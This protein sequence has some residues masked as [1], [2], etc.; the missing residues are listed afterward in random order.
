MGRRTSL[1]A[2][3]AVWVVLC[4]AA[5]IV[6]AQV[7][8]ATVA[9]TVRDAQD[10]AVPGATVTL[11]SDTRGTTLGDAVTNETGDF[12]FPNVLADTYTVRV[13]LQGFKTVTRSDIDVSPGDRVALPPL[14]LEIGGL[15]ETVEVTAEVPLIQAESGERSFA[16]ER[17]SVE[18]LP[19]L[20]RNFASFA[21]LTP[22]VTGDL[23]GMG[24]QSGQEAS[25][26]GGGGQNNVMMDGV[27]AMDTGNNGQMLQMNVES[28][29]QVKVLT[30]GYQAEYG[31]S[32]GLQITAV[33]KSGSNQFR[34]SL[35]DIERNSDWN[36]NTWQRIHNGD[37][38]E[39]ERERDWG[40]T[41]GGPVGRP[42]G[43]NKL[44][45]FYA[46]EYRPRSSAGSINRFRVPTVLEKQGDFSRSV[47]QNGNP[48]NLI[49]DVTTGLPC[50]PGDT[51]GCFQA[52]GVLGRIPQ[53]RLYQTGLNVLDMWGVE[54]NAEGLEF[55]FE[56]P[57]PLVEDLIQ[58]PA[59]RLD[60]QASTNWR[61]TGKYAS[62]R[63]RSGIRA[64]EASIPGFNDVENKHPII[65]NFSTTVNW[66]V[67]NTTFFEAT[68]GMAQNRLVGGG[69][70][71]GILMNESANRFNSGL[72]DLPLLFPDANVVRE[73]YYAFDTLQAYETP[74][75]Q[76][77]RILL[78][79]VFQWGDRIGDNEPPNLL[80]PGW[81][82][83]NRT[84]DFSAS[85]TKL[86]GSHTLKAGFYL[87]HSYKAQNLNAGG[88][89]QFAGTLN[90]GEDT[91]NP[92]DS[93][94]GYANAALG[95]FSTYQQQ[96][97][98]I[99]GSYLYNNIEWYIQDNWKATDRL[100]LDYGVRFTHQ[101]PQYDQFN[102]GSNF[103]PNEWSAANAPALFLPG[104]VNEYPCS[105]DDRQALNPVTGQLMGPGSAAMIGGIVSGSG[106][107]VN[108][109]RQAGDGISKYNYEWPAIAI[110]PR[111]GFA[112]DLTG[113]QRV[114]LRGSWG[115]FF[116]RPDGNSVFS[117][118]GNPPNSVSTTVR[119]GQLQS[120]ASGLR[121]DAVP[122]MIIY[123]YK[124]DNLPTSSQWN[125][126]VQLA[127]PWQSTLD[128]AYV[129]QRSFNVLGAEQAGNDVNLNAVDFG[130]AYV[131]E[132]QDPTRA[133][134]SVPGA[135]ALPTELLRPFQGF[136]NI[137][138]QQQE[139]WR[140]YHSLQFAVRRRFQSGL[141]AG[142]NWNLTLSD[143]G[144][145][146]VPQRLEHGPDGSI[147]RWSRQDEFNELMEDQPTP[148]HI[149]RGHFVWQPPDMPLGSRIA[150]AIVNGWQLS[151]VW[152]GASGAKYTVGYDYENNGDNVNITGSPDYGG[153]VRIF[154]DPGSGCADDQYAQFNAAAFAGPEF[155]SVGMES[156]R[157]YVT[158]C[159]TNIWDM[160]LARNFSIGGTRNLQVRL[161][162]YNLF[163]TVVYNAR[164]T[165]LE[166]DNP[167]DQNILNSQ[168]NA[169]G[170]LN[171]SRLRPAD[172]GF[173]AATNALPLRQL[174][175]Q[176]R[177]SF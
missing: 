138:E 134:S 163:N 15:D 132:N 118:S 157:N 90:F 160:A 159:W 170:S 30:S 87:N 95:I 108:G 3:V 62:Q 158:G 140:E 16:V 49:R 117:Q 161:E 66:N 56:Q 107:P 46:H 81:L 10:A 24:A 113:D 26:I 9:G 146:G 92:I 52:G 11:I 57:R 6:S 48:A 77:G 82:N 72:G 58:Q 106:S 43:N 33:T 177:F 156:G 35:Y 103:F 53:D 39:E 136:S 45:F 112:Y 97:Q 23:P 89:F 174:Q 100:T 123:R 116:D 20:N 96:S 88:G 94:F 25:R 61:I 137:D 67:N 139:F 37:P 54:P 126:G 76:D 75:F 168:F 32:S 83:I 149:L 145:F 122:Q 14:I 129:G 162:V 27:S 12:V 101:Q 176:F 127:I 128:V 169:D 80:F 84:Q 55:N 154:G 119:Y 2:F 8:T 86:W 133:A 98:F 31:R 153:R 22:G 4:A 135:N 125:A 78:P 151:G 141:S 38:K 175:L 74:I 85:L 5:G 131:P 114:V 41:I 109:I 40:Y 17:T 47:D 142:L 148:T 50:E 28:I 69:A 152:T 164:N 110:G 68:Y 172:A 19:V 1:T 42:G 143:T 171:E 147:S 155:G 18:N 36:S 111:V 44:F 144:T 65:H 34:G 13:A 59:I 124:N 130:A 102:Q 21:Q 29:A 60:Y 93:G 63:A 167:V 166:F 79:P 7:T 104:C 173:G 165:T 91:N 51:R 99:E 70:N 73:D 150:E 115:L 105:G 120:L 64:R 121:A 71:F